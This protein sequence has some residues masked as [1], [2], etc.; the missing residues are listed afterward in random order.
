MHSVLVVSKLFVVTCPS[1]HLVYKVMHCLL[2]KLRLQ[3][4]LTQIY[5]DPGSRNVTTLKMCGNGIKEDGED[6][7]TGG[8]PS[9][10]CDPTTCKFKTGAVCE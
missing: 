2:K 9:N 10:C 5:I 8:Q 3:V 4:C 6:C 7:D 1:G